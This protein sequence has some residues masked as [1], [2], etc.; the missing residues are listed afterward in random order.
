MNRKAEQEKAQKDKK[1]KDQLKSQR[2]KG[3]EGTRS[4]SRKAQ[5]ERRYVKKESHGCKREEERWCL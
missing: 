2:Q 1:K 3:D 4:R 5:N